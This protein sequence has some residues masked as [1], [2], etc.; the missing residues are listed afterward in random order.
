MGH[1]E[2]RSCNPWGSNKFVLE[3]TSRF[4]FKASINV[5]Y[6]LMTM[7]CRC[8]SPKPLGL[9]P[10]CAMTQMP[11]VSWHS[12]IQ[13]CRSTTRRHGHSE[14]HYTKILD[15]KFVIDQTTHWDTAT[16]PQDFCIR[17]GFG[18]SN[19][20]NLQISTQ[21]HLTTVSVPQKT[22]AF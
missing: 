9:L 8:L 15:S 22:F 7:E 19:T 13:Q 3:Q 16:C 14:F 10:F 4:Y 6:K 17:F 2:R 5:G 12:T 1:N 11:L 18:L 21:Y 20:R